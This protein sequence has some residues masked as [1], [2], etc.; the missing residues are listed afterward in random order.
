MQA[1]KARPPTGLPRKSVAIDP[2]SKKGSTTSKVEAKQS[3]VGL[4][5]SLISGGSGMS[6]VSIGA[7]GVTHAELELVK[8]FAVITLRVH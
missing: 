8:L 5:P 2:M 3:G 7:P 6:R 1:G 4:R